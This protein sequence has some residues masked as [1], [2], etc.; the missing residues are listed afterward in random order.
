MKVLV[1]GVMEM[2]GTSSKTGAHYEM[3][4]LLIG[5]PMGNA[6]KEK[7]QRRAAGVECTEL[8]CDVATLES[9]LHI[10][11]PQMCEVDTDM[12]P[13]GGRLVPVAVSIKSAEKLQAAA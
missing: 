12:H 8:E 6:S 9:A 13:I 1:L 7:Y 10:R 5:S 3:R 11:L 4:R 2:V